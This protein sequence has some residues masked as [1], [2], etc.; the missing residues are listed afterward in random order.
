M[1]GGACRL[2]GGRRAA[3]A[4]LRRGRLRATAVAGAR[5]GARTAAALAGGRLLLGAP[6]GGRLLLGAPAARRLAGIA[7]GLGLR[8]CLCFLAPGRRARLIV[9][10][11]ARPG[12]GRGLDRPGGLLP[13]PVFG[14]GALL[15]LRLVLE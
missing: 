3:G 5:G 11:V 1:G 15:L 13:I 2:R 9:V 6:A 7:L 8:A 10:V 14:R 4:R 12:A